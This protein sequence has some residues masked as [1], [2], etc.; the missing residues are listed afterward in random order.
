MLD[1]DVA[2]V[3]DPVGA[4]RAHASNSSVSMVVQDGFR[5]VQP[6]CNRHATAMQ[7]P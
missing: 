7:P 1:L 4:M 6:P 5:T 3:R 2:L